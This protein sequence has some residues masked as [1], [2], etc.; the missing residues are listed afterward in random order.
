MDV[1]IR[2]RGTDLTEAIRSYV[3]RRL[4]FSLGR[5][6]SRLGRVTVRISDVN[7]P[8]GG[9]DKVCRISAK[10]TQSGQVVV[11]ETVDANLYAAIDH[12]T[13]RIGQSCGREVRRLRERGTGSIRT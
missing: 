2:I 11:Q 6:A 7:G 1:H 8:R 13:E 4:R 10:L 12:A 9:V 3:E 5:F